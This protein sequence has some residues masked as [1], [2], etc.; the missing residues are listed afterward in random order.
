MSVHIRSLLYSALARV[1]GR[2]I[3][4]RAFVDRGAR[5][6]GRDIRVGDYAYVGARAYLR[7]EYGAS[8]TIEESVD[9]GPECLI[10]TV[11]HDIGPSA[12]RAGPGRAESVTIGR[13]SWLGTRVTVLPGT[14]VGCSCVVGASS[15]L[16]GV[17]PPN[18]LIAGTPA[19]VVRT[20]GP[21]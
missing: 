15:L 8:I 20:L 5:M 6:H 13:G 10:L 17:Y 2:R 7:S 18:S 4:V 3:S 21:G 1:R 9:I 11:T 12:R 14:V 19:R 16:E